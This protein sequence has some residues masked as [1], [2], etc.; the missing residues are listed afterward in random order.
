[1]DR[2]FKLILAVAVL[3]VGSA[4]PSAGQQFEYTPYRGS[5]NTGQPPD[6]PPDNYTPTHPDGP[7][8]GGASGDAAAPAYNGGG[9]DAYSGGNRA[10]GSSGGGYATP[11]GTYSPSEDVFSPARGGRG[12]SPPSVPPPRGVGGPP[13]GD[14]GGDLPRI[15]VQAAAP[16]DG[17]PYSVRKRDAHRAAI[18]GWRSKVAD[19][20]GPEFSHWRIAVGKRV[21]CHPDRRDG[22]IC[23]ASAQPVRGFDRDSSWDPVRR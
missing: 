11:R 17:V 5:N 10:A 14:L 3:L 20:Y 4:A 6:P 13:P 2:P 12:T 9:A 16:D 23:T 21:D 8:P 1:M 18:Q 15:E 19:R 22:I 7:A